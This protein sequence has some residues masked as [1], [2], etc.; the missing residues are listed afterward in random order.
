MAKVNVGVIGCGFW[1]KNHVRVFNEIDNCNLL[2]VADTD[3]RQAR[4]VGEQCRV[5]WF[6]DPL[7]VIENPSIDFISICTPTITH[8]TLALDAIKAG[9]HILAEKPMTSTSEEAKQVIAAARK[10]DVYVMVGFI[11]RFNPAVRLAEKMIQENKIG[12]PV[13]ASA[14]RVSR[15][16]IRI[17]DVGVVKDLAIHDIDL[18]CH[19]FRNPVTQVYASA[20]SLTHKHADYAN[21]MMQFQG[22]KS[23]FIEANWLTPRKIRRLIVT[24]TEGII[25]VEYITQKV[26]LENQ[27][28]IVTPF[29]QTAEPLKLELEH[30][31]TSIA[32][33]QPPVPNG[34]E[35][36]Q[37]LIICEA[38]LQSAQ[39]QAPVNPRTYFK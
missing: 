6:A 33:D 16:P 12:T 14:K 29:F 20:G 13:L 10:A 37:A 24:G 35:G 1:G 27:K 8:A 32:Q 18:I 25:Q 23:A 17:S 38:A 28:M 7:K 21:I 34:E 30:F 15:W 36:L 5:D 11:E 31:I 2:A 39:Q 9:K 26:I 4:R 22:G 3:S 19:I